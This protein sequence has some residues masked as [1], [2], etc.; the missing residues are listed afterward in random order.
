MSSN[1]IGLSLISDLKALKD[2]LVNIDKDIRFQTKNIQVR[3]KCWEEMQDSFAKT[4]QYSNKADRISIDVG[5]QKFVTTKQ[6]LLNAKNSLFEAIV[7][8]PEIDLT[9]ELFFDRSSELFSHLLEYLRTGYIN[10]KLFSKDQKKQL[11][12][13]AKYY[14][15]LDVI[16]YL[17]ER[18][19]D[20]EYV[21]FEFTGPYLYKGQ[22][23]GSNILED[24]RINDLMIGGICSSVPGNITFKL[25]SDWEIN[26]IEVGGYK[27]STTIWYPENG[28]GATIST[29]EDGKTWVVVGKI[30]SGFGKEVKTIKLKTSVARYLKFSHNSYLGI[31]Y[32]NIKK[33]E[34]K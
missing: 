4:S 9:K 2:R 15:L 10:Y 26:E 14:Q 8:D 32:L 19:K 1:G 21:S 18:L 23:A 12:E 11:L 27:G 20:I 7:N 6:T 5:G 17:Q 28:S 16:N 33:I 13:E 3:D 34:D 30:P 29:S 31:S 24:L 25:N 22:T